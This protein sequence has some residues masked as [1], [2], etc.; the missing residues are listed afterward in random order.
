MHHKVPERQASNPKTY[1]LGMSV[2]ANALEQKSR[3]ARRATYHA[4]GFLIG[5]WGLGERELTFLRDLSTA[6]CC[7]ISESPLQVGSE[8]ALS[9]VASWSDPDVTVEVAKVRW[10]DGNCYGLE[11]LA[12]DPVQRER[13]R[14]FL[15]TL[16]ASPVPNPGE[17]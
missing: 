15:K 7:V 11:F 12:I 8:W 14:L 1:G 6:G 13:L 5:K 2:K 10:A 16:E 4:R 3:K 9:L 17:V